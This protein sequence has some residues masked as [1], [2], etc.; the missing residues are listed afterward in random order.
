MPAHEQNECTCCQREVAQLRVLQIGEIQI[1]RN[2]P[3]VSPRSDRVCRYGQQLVEDEWFNHW[4]NLYK[5]ID[6][7][8]SMALAIVG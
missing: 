3:D 5:G 8:P 4:Q 6:Q 2:G 7:T 1:V